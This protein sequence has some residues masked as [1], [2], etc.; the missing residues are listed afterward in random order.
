M[1]IIAVPIDGEIIQCL[2]SCECFAIAKAEGRCIKDIEF[3]SPIKHF[4][5]QNKLIDLLNEKGVNTILTSQMDAELTDSLE[6]NS[7][8]IVNSSGEYTRAIN[9]YL[10]GRLESKKLTTVINSIKI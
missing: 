10:N 6:K 2:G 8:E 4:Y 5:H 7:V 9:D 3:V 1:L